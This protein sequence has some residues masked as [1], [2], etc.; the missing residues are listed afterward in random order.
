MRRDSQISESTIRKYRGETVFGWEHEP[1][2]ERPSEFRQSTRY[3]SLMTP[4]T[5]S[6]VSGTLEIARPRPP[7][8]RGGSI[9]NVWVAVVL[10]VA[11]AGGAVMG[12]VR[13]MHGAAPAKP[14]RSAPG[15][16]AR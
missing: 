11:L 13:W 9:V 6:T 1:S 3:D 15:Q 5:R 10:V 2:D 7:R 4:L 14:P 8:K 16:P 12:V